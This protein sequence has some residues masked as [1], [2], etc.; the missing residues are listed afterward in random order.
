MDNTEKVNGKEKENV[1]CKVDWD[2][3]EMTRIFCNIV[4]K[5]IDA[6]NWPLGTFNLRGYKNL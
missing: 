6:W 4:V 2:N 1:V 5:E 3:P